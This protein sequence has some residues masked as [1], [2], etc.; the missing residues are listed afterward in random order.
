MSDEKHAQD[1]EYIC[2]DAEV[3]WLLTMLARKRDDPEWQAVLNTLRG[4][5]LEELV[6]H[7][8]SLKRE[9]SSPTAINGA[10]LDEMYLDVGKAFDDQFSVYLNWILKA[11][12]I[13]SIS[14]AFNTVKDGSFKR[15][16]KI[17]KLHIPTFPFGRIAAQLL[18]KFGRPEKYSK[19][20]V[21]RRLQ[22]AI[23]Q[24][25]PNH[26]RFTRSRLAAVFYGINTKEYKKLPK[27]ERKK[28]LDAF[29]KLLKSKG[30][31][32]KKPAS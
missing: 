11:S 16:D 5:L 7:V 6:K 29:N 28:L 17:S 26:K 22:K 19:E 31:D 12:L 2:A 8:C 13:G 9:E 20:E 10:T 3:R 1:E 21:E 14:A 25:P 23:T 18:G 32:Y 30:L 15:I 27:E 24:M 4:Q